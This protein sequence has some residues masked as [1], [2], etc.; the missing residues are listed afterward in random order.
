MK[1]IN[2]QLWKSILVLLSH[3]LSSEGF[4]YD[5]L[6][7]DEK[8]KVPERDFNYL[9]K[10]VKLELSDYVIS[11]EG[12][13]KKSKYDNP[14]DYD[15]NDWNHLHDAVLTA[16]GKSLNNLDL[17]IIFFRLPEE[18]KKLAF[19]WGMSDTEFREKVIEYLKNNENEN[20]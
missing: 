16:S 9:M 2:G 10:Y 5:K 17:A 3:R 8:A 4:C 20:V 14:K 11:N 19:N 13:L 12:D 18:L 15:Q 7:D 6:S 1:K